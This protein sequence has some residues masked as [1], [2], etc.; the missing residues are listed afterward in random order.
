IT[1]A[2]ADIPWGGWLENAGQED[3][4]QIMSSGS[5]FVVFPSATTTQVMLQ[6][7]ET[8]KILELESSLGEGLLRATNSLPV[9]AVL[10]TGEDMEDYSLTWQHLMLFQRFADLLA[11]PLLVPAPSNVTADELQALWKAGVDGVVVKVTSQQSASKLSE[12]HHLIDK[13]DFPS[14]RRREKVEPLLPHFNGANNETP[15]EEEEEEGE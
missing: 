1:K 7:T 13:L 11:K 9:D 5:D 8:G 2:A 12:L 15:P 10:I 4:K 3:M 6:K 14:P